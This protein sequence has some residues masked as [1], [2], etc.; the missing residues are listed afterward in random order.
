MRKPKPTSIE[1][2][3]RQKSI[4]EQMARRHSSPEQQIRRVKLILSM[5]EGKNNQQTA[6]ALDMHP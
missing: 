1:L 4:L 3:E 6:I 5:A 2:S